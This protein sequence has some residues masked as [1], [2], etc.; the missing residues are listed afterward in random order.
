MEKEAFEL[1]QRDVEQVC[2]SPEYSRMSESSRVEKT[3]F[4]K[5]KV[6]VRVGME[7]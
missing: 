5:A 6:Q 3:K 2:S 4:L 1:D 7:Q